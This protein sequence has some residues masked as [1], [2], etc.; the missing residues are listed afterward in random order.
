MLSYPNDALTL[1]PDI[2][3][4]H[5]AEQIML[6]AWSL[7]S[8]SL[9][10]FETELGHDLLTD[11]GTSRVHHTDWVQRYMED[12]YTPEINYLK[13]LVGITKKK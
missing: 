8:P 4:S 5:P 2:N 3:C 6:S 9:K 7:I 10:E 13:E 12:E 1:R 11:C